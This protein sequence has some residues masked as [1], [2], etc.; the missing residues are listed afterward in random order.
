MKNGM[1]KSKAAPDICCLCSLKTS[2]LSQ[3]IIPLRI[4]QIFPVIFQEE[5]F[6][7]LKKS[8]ILNLGLNPSDLRISIICVLKKQKAKFLSIW[9][10]SIKITLNNKV[11]FTVRK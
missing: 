3:K 10:K 2:I 11:I 1:Y 9:P 4:S 5:L 7:T 8:D 6:F